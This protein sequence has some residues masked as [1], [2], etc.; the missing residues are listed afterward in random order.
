LI[1]EK[2]DFRNPEIKKF[3]SL[4]VSG[5]RCQVSGDRRRKAQGA[6]H[7]AKAQTPNLWERLSPPA[8]PERLAMAG[9]QPRSVIP[10]SAAGGYPWFDRL[11]TLSEVEGESRDHVSLFSP[12]PY[13][14]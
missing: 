11:T 10:E 13:A 7:K 1:G 6:R 8:S 4:R 14:L 5:V 9:R 3:S 12:F 2:L